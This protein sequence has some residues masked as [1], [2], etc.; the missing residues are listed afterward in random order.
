M[1]IY[2][3]KK[4]STIGD[5]ERLVQ[6]LICMLLGFDSFQFSVDCP[7]GRVHW[8]LLQADQRTQEPVLCPL[9]TLWKL[10]VHTPPQ[11]GC[12][13]GISVASYIHVIESC[14]STSPLTRVAS[15]EGKAWE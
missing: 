1:P 3:S 9:G 13:M 12:G 8:E 6:V 2:H 7:T 5:S 14:R 10:P 4:K 15:H 11:L